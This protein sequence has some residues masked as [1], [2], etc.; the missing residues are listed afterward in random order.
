LREEKRIG[1]GSEK[2]GKERREV[3]GE[4]VDRMK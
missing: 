3:E 4:G 2:K 1:E